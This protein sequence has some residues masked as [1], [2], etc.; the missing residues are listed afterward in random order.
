MKKIFLSLLLVGGLLSSCDMDKTPVGTLDETTAIQSVNDCFRFRNGIYSSMRSLS[1]GAYISYSEIQMDMFQGLTSNGNRIGIIAN[2]NIL[3]SDGDIEAMWA[4]LYTRINNVNF[5]LEKASGVLENTEISETNAADIARYIGE[6][7]FARAYYYYWL[8]DHF[9]GVYSAENGDKEGLGLPIVTVYNPTGDRS[10]YPGRSSMNDTYAFIDQDLTEAYD[11]LV[12]YEAIDNSACAPN[13]AYV[14]TYTVDALRAR[15]ALLKGDY[16]T[17][18]TKAETVIN[19]QVYALAEGDDYTNMWETDES[20]EVIFSPFVNVDE[21]GSISST[22]SAWLSIY[23]DNADYVPTYDALAM[24]EDGDVRF[25]AFFN[26]WNL[27]ING[28]T[29]PAFVFYKYPGNESLKIGTAMNLMNRPKPFRLSEQYLILAEAAAATGTQNK[30]ANDALNALRAKRIAGYVA[31]EYTS[32]QLRDQ[33]RAERTK[34]LIGEGFRISDLRRWGLGFER[35][36]SHP[37]NPYIEDVLVVA[38]KALSYSAGD[39][40]FVWPIPSAEMET[41]PQL[42][43]QQNPGY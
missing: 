32:V 27:S 20:S 13:S 15:L 1:T 25:N 7:K 36:P 24:Y 39:H 21:V 40:R 31:Q 10:K 30:K 41:N 4:G 2:G 42:A 17:A 18:I 19:S 16:E 5:F 14:S 37:E 29:I 3:S 43:G 6:A 8:M 33:I 28:S 22:G 26:V 23:G 38:G 12:A 35:N 11:A 9:C 34:E